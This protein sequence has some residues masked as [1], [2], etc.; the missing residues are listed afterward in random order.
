MFTP[1]WNDR[2][3]VTHPPAR[4]PVSEHR[5][6]TFWDV[7]ADAGPAFGERRASRGLATGDLDG[8]GRPEIVIVNMNDKPAVL[9]NDRADGH[10]SM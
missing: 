9:K 4:A 8:D 1:K 3:S 10:F 5:Q 7:T 2:V 6:R